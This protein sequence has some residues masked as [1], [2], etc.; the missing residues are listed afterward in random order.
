MFLN[1]ATDL[2]DDVC[3]GEPSVTDKDAINTV[4]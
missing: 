3:A 4:R 2:N 1:S